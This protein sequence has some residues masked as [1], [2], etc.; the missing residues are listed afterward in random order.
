MRSRQHERHF[1]ATFLK[2]RD[3]PPPA[4][5]AL[6][7][8]SDP[9]LEAR[10]ISRRLTPRRRQVLGKVVLPEQLEVALVQ[11]V[12][13]A[14]A[15]DEVVELTGGTGLFA[16]VGAVHRQQQ[17]QHG[18]A[19]QRLDGAGLSARCQGLSNETMDG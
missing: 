16:V 3:S 15:H 1:L 10:G 11:E 2:N 9:R 19:L 6:E 17:L 5:V 4:S 14:V 12:V 8:S 13:G 18:V 7:H